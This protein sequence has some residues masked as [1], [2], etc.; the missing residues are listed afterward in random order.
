MM[1]KLMLAL[2]VALGALTA[3]GAEEIPKREFR[4]AWLH[5][6]GQTQY[7]N[8][9]P[10]QCRAYISEQLDRLA[11]AGCNAVIFQ[12]RPTADAMYKS[13]IEPWSCWLT[14]KRG[15]APSPEWD[16]LAYT[17]EE[18]HRRG[19]ELHAWLNPYRVTSN[20]KEVLPPD[21]LYNKERH[22]FFRYDNK[23]FFDPAYPENRDY[24]CRVVAD[25]V[26]RYDVDAI[27]MDDYFYPYPVGGGFNADTE[28][29]AK[30]GSGQNKGDWR[31]H[32][33]D[34]LIEKLHGTIK[35]LKP[36]VRFGISPFGIW[37]NKRTDPRGSESAGL[38]NYDD[39]YADVL[40][41]ADKG[42]IDY[43]APQLYWEL[44][45][46]VAPSRKLA[47]WWNDNVKP[48]VQLY[49]GQDTKRTMDKPTATDKNELA[50]KIDISRRLPRVDGNVWW[51]GYWVT[52]NY[53]GA[54]D[55]LSSVHQCSLAIPP[56]W[57]GDGEVPAKVQGLR[58]GERDSKKVVEWDYPS[59]FAGYG[60]KKA[61]AAG[62][63]ATDVV[64]FV[65]YQFFPGETVDI[66]DPAAIIA[67]TPFNA[68]RVDNAE[69]GTVFIVTALD[70]L[71]RE[72]AP[73]AR[74]IVK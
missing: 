56:A 46:K 64:K 47:Q 49:I 55:A 4:G 72:S 43:V 16:P 50:T 24:I 19:M 14:G 32:N 7:M 69:K 33:V 58:P 17:V 29:Y 44:D 26:S 36:W 74:L 52:G 18:A 53:K 11:E 20:P 23:I 45:L 15:K 5:V 9:T 42:W 6:I 54:L 61:G 10:E 70:R 22:R 71:N 73:S 65:V 41:W 57:Q 37:R 13:D 60:S 2:I 63:R 51:H 3:S 21:H 27:H 40:L 34:L 67:V 1:K 39:L 59:N 38:Q 8:K 25:I 62:G 48:P 68:V 28:S 31:R 30:F 66:S 12:V 35:S